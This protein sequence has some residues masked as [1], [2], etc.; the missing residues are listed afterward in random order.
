VTGNGIS[1]LVFIV[2]SAVAEAERDRT[3]ER[4]S[5]VKR[6]QKARE[7]YL[8]GVVPFGWT[9]GEG[10]DLVE[11]EAQQRAI[12]QMVKLR[13]AG[14]SLRAVRDAMKGEGFSFPTSASGR[15]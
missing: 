1:K 7:R 15:L 4:I 13:E 11:D 10:G 3:R 8:G 9:V 14:E 12:R 6:D 5:D 2:L